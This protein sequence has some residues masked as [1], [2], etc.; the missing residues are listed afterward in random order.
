[1]D[2]EN[3]TSVHD[4]TPSSIRIQHKNDNSKE[5]KIL[6][7]TFGILLMFGLISVIAYLLKSSYFEKNEASSSI[8]Q[9]KSNEL[10]PTPTPKYDSLQSAQIYIN[11]KYGFS[12]RYP[13]SLS[14]EGFSSAPEF[15]YTLP[16]SDDIVES[17]AIGDDFIHVI[18]YRNTQNKSL[19]TWV[20]EFGDILLNQSGILVGPGDALIGQYS[21]KYTEQPLNKI[22]SG[23]GIGGQAAYF[24]SHV[25]YI[26]KKDDN[27]FLV[28]Y[29]K[30]ELSPSP[31]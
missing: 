14:K 6:Y 22:P 24:N 1:M 2:L 20:E 17:V 31:Q 21:A 28:I 16:F 11:E 7:I 9:S 12:F 18:I 4:Q 5:H 3:L 30:V 10:F 27:I 29:N 13:S 19:N 8:K 15:D 23:G 25:I 26:T